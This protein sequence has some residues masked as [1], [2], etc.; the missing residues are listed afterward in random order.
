MYDPRSLVA[1]CAACHVAIHAHFPR[2]KR[3]ETPPQ[4]GTAL[5]GQEKTPRLG[6][7]LR[8]GT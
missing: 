1:L 4:Q 7:R 3:P 5:L 6:K 8:W 2:K